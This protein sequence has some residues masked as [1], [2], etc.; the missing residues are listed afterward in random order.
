MKII[1]YT[2]ILI[3]TI[4][5]VF[6]SCDCSS[7]CNSENISKITK[8][9]IQIPDSLN[10]YTMGFSSGIG[11]GIT[12]KGIT[13]EGNIEFYSISDR[14]PNYTIQCSN[15]TNDTI[16]FPR[17]DF[18]PF[19]GVVS[20]TPNK[21]ATLTHAISIKTNG[22]KITGLPIPEVASKEGSSIPTDLTFKLIPADTKG[23]DTE[24]IDVDAEGNFWLGDEYRP[25]LI[26][27]EGATGEITKVLTPGNGLPEILKHIQKNRGFEA[28]AIAPNGKIYAAIEGILDFNGQTTNSA[29]FIR[30]IELD[31]KTSQTRTL[32]YPHDKDS[33]KTPLAAKIGDLAAIDNSHF[34]IIE[35]GKTGNGMRNLIYIIDI[36]QA[37]DISNTTLTDGRPLEYASPEELLDIQFIKKSPICNAA[38]CQWPHEKLEGIAIIDSKTIAIT[39]DNDF[40][41]S[42]SINDINSERVKEYSVDFENQQLLRHNKQTQDKVDI[43]INKTASTDIWIIELKKELLN[44][45]D[46]KDSSKN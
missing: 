3:S 38:E 22:Q 32:A 5:Q 10:E 9:E 11:S 4:H 1:S 29:N 27:V 25:S 6:A 43:K 30:I 33:Y 18:S 23:F 35:Q 36:T 16:I 46:A 26:K 42:L 39:N 17:P 20:L 24:S 8:Y 31:P 45:M 40:G 21:S 13:K 12:L 2:I 41:F 14:G 44:F 15:H 37:T 19:I 34:L 7:N 28:L